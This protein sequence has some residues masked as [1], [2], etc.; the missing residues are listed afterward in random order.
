VKHDDEKNRGQGSAMPPGL[1]SLF[2]GLGD[3]LQVAAGMAESAGHVSASD[4][5]GPR[6]SRFAKR[7]L[8]VFGV[9]VRVAPLAGPLPPGIPTLRRNERRPAV[10]AREPM[11]DVFDEGDFVVVVAELPGVD[12]SAVQWTVHGGDVLTICA[13]APDRQYLK[14]IKLPAAVDDQTVTSCHANGVVELKLW[15]RR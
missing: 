11:T 12:E 2:R 3:L 1:H 5:R 13:E 10:D 8:G 15:K 6:R 7:T 14:E 4:L 9:N